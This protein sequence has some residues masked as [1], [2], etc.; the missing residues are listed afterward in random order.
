V[1]IAQLPDFLTGI[2]PATGLLHPLSYGDFRKANTQSNY[3]V[4]WYTGGWGFPG[5][6]GDDKLD[7]LEAL[8][9]LRIM[10]IAYTDKT[11]TVLR[12]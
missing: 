5:P 1:T 12:E 2:P 10:P 8:F 7:R 11:I 4:C 3:L 9:L 6:L